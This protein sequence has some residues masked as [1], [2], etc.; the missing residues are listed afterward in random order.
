[1]T[2]AEQVQQAATILITT[3]VFELVGPVGTRWVLAGAGET[4]A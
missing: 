2:E 1:M 4:S 3:V